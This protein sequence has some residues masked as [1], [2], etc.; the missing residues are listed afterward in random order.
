MKC[1]FVVAAVTGIAVSASLGGEW[2]SYLHSNKVS[3]IWTDESHVYW[4]STGGVVTT[5]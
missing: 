1:F 2:E 5:A 4:G 3:S